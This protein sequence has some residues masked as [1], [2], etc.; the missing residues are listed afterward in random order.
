MQVYLTY[1]DRPYAALE[2]ANRLIKKYPKNAV[3]YRYFGRCFVKIGNWVEVNRVYSTVLELYNKKQRGYADI[4]AREAEFYLGLSCF[5]SEELD[6][7]I[8]HFLKCDKISQEIDKK[9]NSG[10]MV[11]ANLRIGMIYD[12]QN[13]RKKAL[14]QYSKVLKMD[15]YNDSHDQAKRFSKQPYKK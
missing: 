1:E 4:E 10:Y 13:N 3:F 6:K 8:E 7:S 12:I 14:D 2:I 15:K 9:K 5:H 11:L